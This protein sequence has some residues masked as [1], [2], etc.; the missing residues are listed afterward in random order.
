MSLT[1]AAIRRQA[2]AYLDDTVR[3]LNNLSTP[4]PGSPA[5]IVT[6]RSRSWIRPASGTRRDKTECRI[7]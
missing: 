3:Y 7:R 6:A 5:R 2:A 4:A 1:L